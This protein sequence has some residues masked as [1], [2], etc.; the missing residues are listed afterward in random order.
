VRNNI[1]NGFNT[2]SYNEF[3]YEIKGALLYVGTRR[4][5]E[6]EVGGVLQALKGLM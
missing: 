2:C 4:I 6:F 1:Y 3:L 5:A